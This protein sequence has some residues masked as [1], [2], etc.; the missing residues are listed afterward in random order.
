MT[1]PPLW[2]YASVQDVE[3]ANR[4]R[5]LGQGANPTQQD[6]E[7]FLEQIAGE[8]DSVLINKGYSCPYPRPR[9]PRARSCAK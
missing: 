8:I 9:A 7:G 4:A 5:V 1:P 6:V 2:P 3:S